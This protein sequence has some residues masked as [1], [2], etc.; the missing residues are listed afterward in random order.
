MRHF[1]VC[2]VATCAV[3]A[4]TVS[5]AAAKNGNGTVCVLHAKL[6]AKNETT[7]STSTA[8]GHTLIKVRT[9]G[10]IEFK[11]QINNRNH[12]TFIAGHIHQAPVGVAGPIVVPLFVSPA[13]ATNARHIKQSGIATPNAGTTGAALCANPSAYY[14]NYHTTVFMGGAIRGQLH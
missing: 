5:V 14:V 10:R 4:L 8:K 3:A 11:T 13:P 2:L 1:L 9:D 12:E 6:A 7:G